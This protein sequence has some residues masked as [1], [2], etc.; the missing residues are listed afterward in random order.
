MSKNG[1]SPPRVEKRTRVVAADRE[2]LQNRAYSGIF[3]VVTKLQTQR[4]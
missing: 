3:G 2:D 4:Y 1:E